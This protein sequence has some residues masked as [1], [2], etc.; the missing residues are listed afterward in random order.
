MGHNAVPH[1]FAEYPAG[2]R[3]VI[4]ASGSSHDANRRVECRVC[5]LAFNRSEGIEAALSNPFFTA[6]YK[7]PKMLFQKLCAFYLILRVNL[8]GSKPVI[9]GRCG[10]VPRRGGGVRRG[11]AGDRGRLP[12]PIR[13]FK[14][15]RVCLVVL[16]AKL[17]SCS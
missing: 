11:A 17:T 6:L 7:R 16:M 13:S 8:C 15:G 1:S 4:F 9:G 12:P 14:R 3:R 5:C 2:C 10:G